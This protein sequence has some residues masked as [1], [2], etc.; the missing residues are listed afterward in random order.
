MASALFVEDE[1]FDQSHPSHP[2]CMSNIFHALDYHHWNSNVKKVLPHRKHV[3]VIK[4]AKRNRRY[5]RISDDQDSFE[6]LKL[7]DDKTSHMQMDQRNKKTSSTQKR[8]LKARIKALVSENDYKQDQDHDSASSPKL[9][10]TYSIH[11]LESNE[12]VD[13]IVFFHE[14]VAVSP[15]SSKTQDNVTHR[16]IN[17]SQDILEMFEIDKKLF[18]NTL[19]D[20][21]KDSDLKPKLTKSGSFPIA[22]KSG[23]RSLMPMKLKDKVNESYTI[24]KSRKIKNSNDDVNSNNSIR[25][26]RISSLNESAD[27]YTQLFDFSVNKEAALRSSR[28]LKLTNGS[29]SMLSTRQSSSSR[30]ND[31]I[32]EPY[33]AYLLKSFSQ[34]DRNMVSLDKDKYAE[35]NSAQDLESLNEVMNQI[36]SI[37]ENKDSLEFSKHSHGLKIEEDDH[38]ISQEI[39][40]QSLVSVYENYE[41]GQISEGLSLLNNSHINLK[42]EIKTV[43]SK[44]HLNLSIE[45]DD[46]TYVKKLLEQ[47]GFLNNEFHQTWH[48]SNQPLDPFL[49]QELESQYFHD[50]TRF[51]EEVNELSRRLLIFDL[52]DEFLLTMYERSS[53]YYPKKLSSFCHIH[54][55]PTG[56]LDFSEVWDHLSRMISLKH[57]MNECLNDIVA[58]DLRSDDGWMNLQVDSECV[59]L[60]LEELI[61]DEILEEVLLEFK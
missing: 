37:S 50:P 61:F 53:T 55:V 9:H 29:E 27:R 12:W 19:Q 54:P 35:L 34:N 7:L 42:N 31:S 47:S 56:S 16:E 8:S 41:K 45:D 23:S 44:K 30:K 24:S 51:A 22:F 11:R 48:S 57:E 5:Q 43:S 2:G 10:R 20:Q 36:D 32:Q 6:V 40:Q 21:S 18:I 4:N 58:R 13:P 39:T 33:D 1:Q 38:Q 15:V 14:N 17:D 59:G 3:A 26:R 52:V 28:S 25:L 60:D 49:F 46:F